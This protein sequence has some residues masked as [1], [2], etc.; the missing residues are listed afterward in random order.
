MEILMPLTVVALVAIFLKLIKKIPDL[1]IL[2][3]VPI[4]TNVFIHAYDYFSHGYLDPFWKV[5]LVVG[6]F[7][8]H[9]L[10]V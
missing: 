2:F 8:L 9:L 3:M 7:H 6:F 10:L 1:Y 5:A 4:F